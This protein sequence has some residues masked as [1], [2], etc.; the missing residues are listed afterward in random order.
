MGAGPVSDEEH[1]RHFVDAHREERDVEVFG[2]GELASSLDTTTRAIRFYES[3]GLLSPKRVG[4][5]RVYGRRER[6]RLVLILRGK[7]LG[8]SLREIGEYLDLYGER[9][10]GRERQLVH[11]IE[12]SATRIAELRERQSKIEQTI[13]ELE[14]IRDHSIERLQQLRSPG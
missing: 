12:G 14:L 5:T 4:N 1:P 11:V 7:A 3:K 2:I 10:E 8:L 6:A 9:G 13:R